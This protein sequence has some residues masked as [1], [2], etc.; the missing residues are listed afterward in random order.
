MIKQVSYQT[1]F[2]MPGSRN[3][4]YGHVGTRGNDETGV[5]QVGNTL[6]AVFWSVVEKRGSRE[7][8][9]RIPEECSF[10]EETK[11]WFEKV[12]S[13]VQGKENNKR[14]RPQKLSATHGSQ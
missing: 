4:S 6:N 5:D 1:L 7:D 8:L 11:F 10:D 14:K 12:K 9:I 13:Q 2:V 3:L